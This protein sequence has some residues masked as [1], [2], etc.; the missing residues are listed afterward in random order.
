ML[1][2]IIHS[3]A[4]RRGLLLASCCSLPVTCSLFQLTFVLLSCPLSALPCAAVISLLATTRTMTWPAISS[5]NTS[6]SHN[7]TSPRCRFHPVAVRVDFCWF[8]C[9]NIVFTCLISCW[10]WSTDY[11]F[12]KAG[13]EP[14]A[15][16][17]PQPL[18]LRHALVCA[19][20][21]IAEHICRTSNAYS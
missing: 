18:V 7:P 19:H 17:Q 21:T 20:T 6:R 3:T 9:C 4:L 16:Q 12:G 11:S 8:P 5:S 14:D 15:C 10:I 2:C 13:V 1:A